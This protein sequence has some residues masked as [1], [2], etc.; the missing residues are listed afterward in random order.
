MNLS[1]L[2]DPCA[3]LGVS[4]TLAHQETVP[5]PISYPGKL[6]VKLSK[7][8][9][10]SNVLVHPKHGVAEAQLN[11]I[12]I[13]GWTFEA[14]DNCYSIFLVQGIVYASHCMVIGKAL[15]E[16]N[17][18]PIRSSLPWRCRCRRTRSRNCFSPSRFGLIEAQLR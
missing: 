11:N 5:S 8:W 3:Y 12:D 1:C 13:A 9:P 15:H 18:H 7:F 14:Q 10:K 4:L 2:C 16:I 6:F 17:A